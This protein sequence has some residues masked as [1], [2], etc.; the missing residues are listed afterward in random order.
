MVIDEI[1][2]CFECQPVPLRFSDILSFFY[3]NVLCQP[4]EVWT[5]L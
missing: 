5:A 1:I 2:L 3:L 4:H